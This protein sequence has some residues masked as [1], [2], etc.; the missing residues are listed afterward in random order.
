[1]CLINAYNDT[2]NIP[3]V[4]VEFDLCKRREHLQSRT[5]NGEITF[6]DQIPTK[7]TSYLRES[8]LQIFT[9][10]I[11]ELTFPALLLQRILL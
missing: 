1:M 4:A 6:A 8:Y 11:I 2:P 7:A 10:L 5:S 9:I 3:G